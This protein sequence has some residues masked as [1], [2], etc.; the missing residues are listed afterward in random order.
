M[1]NLIR[2]YRKFNL[3]QKD[4]LATNL[5]LNPILQKLQN[6][7]PV[8]KFSLRPSSIGLILNDISINKRN[9]IL[10][11]GAGISTIFTAKFFQLNEIKGQIYAIDHDANWLNWLDDYLQKEKLLNFVQLI[12]SP[13]IPAHNNPFSN[14]LQWYDENRLMAEIGATK[15]DL[16]LI[17]GPPGQG[18][19]HRYYALPFLLKNEILYTKY[20]IIL[21]DVNRDIEQLIVEKWENETELEFKIVNHKIA[22]TSKGQFYATA[23][24]INFK[25]LKIFQRIFRS[26][27]SIFNRS[28]IVFI[29]CS[30]QCDLLINS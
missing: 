15:F 25:P 7:L 9:S 14:N 16:V 19:A 6:Y 8:N 23:Q 1:K 17:D 22:M 26:I 24:F 3:R 28:L 30:Y 27:N 12:H 11:F 18:K 13:L 20:L 2:K 21:D 5:L 10:E 29:T 4:I